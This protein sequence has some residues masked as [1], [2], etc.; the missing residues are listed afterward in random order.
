ME[1]FY[2][3]NYKDNYKDECEDQQNKPI[4][5]Q[6]ENILEEKESYYSV[7]MILKE[8]FKKFNI[9]KDVITQVIQSEDIKKEKCKICTYYTEYTYNKHILRCNSCNHINFCKDCHKIIKFDWKHKFSR[10]TN[11]NKL[12]YCESCNENLQVDVCTVKCLI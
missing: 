10:R 6:I 8:L 3:D 9:N 2:K 12:I 1:T 7:D 5:K 11:T 4:I